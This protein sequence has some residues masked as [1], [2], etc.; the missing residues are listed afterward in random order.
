MFNLYV[1]LSQNVIYVPANCYVEFHIWR[2]CTATKVWYEW[3]V[4]EP[5]ITN[6]HN[7]NGRSYWIGL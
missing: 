6:I 4:T 7:P 1:S 5:Q 3:C 2:L